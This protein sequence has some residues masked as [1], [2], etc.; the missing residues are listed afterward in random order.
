MSFPGWALAMARRSCAVF[1]GNDSRT[2][3]TLKLSAITATVRRSF[4]GS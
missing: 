1:T 4:G 3:S 2:I